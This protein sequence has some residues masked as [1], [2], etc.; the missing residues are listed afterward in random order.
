MNIMHRFVQ[1]EEF[2]LKIKGKVYFNFH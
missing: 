1:I 2:G